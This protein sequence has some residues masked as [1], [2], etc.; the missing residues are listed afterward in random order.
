MRFFQP[1]PYV[2]LAAG[3]VAALAA[4]AAL[5]QTS[6]GAAASSSL[7]PTEQL[8]VDPFVFDVGGF[9]VSSNINGSLSGNANTD[10][11]SL[12]FDKTFGT[13]AD[14]TRVR[15]DFLWRITPR[16]AVSFAYFS[17]SVSR[18]RT[19]D[20]DIPWGDYTFLANAQ[21][22]AQTKF[23]IYQGSYEFAFLNNRDY[24]LALSAGI[25]VD[26]LTIKLAG[27]ATVTLPDGTVQSAS[28]STKSSSLTAPLPVVGLGGAWAATPHL[29]V[30]ASAQLFAYRYQG[31]D[32]N[33]NLLWAGATWMFNHHFG[34]GLG[35][36]RFQTNLDLNKGS[37]N[38]R[39]NLGYQGAVL[40]VRGGF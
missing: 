12:N 4:G 32:G 23:H 11:Q 16:Q 28:Y 1:G 29:Y 18:T 31:I 19:L 24:K 15:A 21:T 27:D 25:H 13:N 30:D 14:Q 40:Y 33:W 8:L 22:T 39:L 7:T 10:N 38:G 2:A 5:A 17:D 9:I 36:N 26:E 3:A 37:F 20:Q 35:Y 34:L 6:S